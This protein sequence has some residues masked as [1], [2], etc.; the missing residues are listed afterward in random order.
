MFLEQNEEFASAG[1]DKSGHWLRMGFSSPQPDE[2][3]GKYQWCPW[4]V[5]QHTFVFIPPSCGYVDLNSC[6]SVSVPAE[7]HHKLP[8]YVL[9]HYQSLLYCHAN[10]QNCLEWIQ[11]CNV[12]MFLPHFPSC[13]ALLMPCHE[14]YP[15]SKRNRTQL[16][17]GSKTMNRTQPWHWYIVTPLQFSVIT[18]I[19]SLVVSIQSCEIS[20][21]AKLEYSIKH[22]Q[23]KHCFHPMCSNE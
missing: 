13:L 22:L 19:S 10:M 5:R 17:R 23:I 3:K 8:N 15:Q 11:R 16:N 6:V 4:I 18:L 2:T 21:C 1:F 12:E 20:F 9:F 14:P 7:T